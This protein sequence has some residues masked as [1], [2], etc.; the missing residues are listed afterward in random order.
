MTDGVIFD[1]DGTLIDSMEM[2]KN[3]DY[4]FLK[5]VGA[6]PDAD[7]TE[8]VNKMTLKEGIA[9]TK[10]RYHLPMSEDEILETIRQMAN[11]FYRGR[12]GLKPYV[13]EFLEELSKR[14][15]PMV[16]ATSSQ[17][18]FIL[19]ALKRNHAEHYF[20]DILSCA[21]L[22][23]NKTFPDV[24]LK[25][26]DA[27]GVRPENSWVIE[28][29]YHALMTAKNA[30]FRVAAVYDPSNDALLE[31]TIREADLYMEDLRDFDRFI[32]TTELFV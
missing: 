21:E 4:D 3:L 13:R 9:Y 31:E 23:I 1:A 24:F 19:N 32:K 28:D 7:Y 2:W 30:G 10:N 22:G 11:S 16:I 29:S 26:A 27:I 18:D 20:Q 12:A 5:S 8:T 14:K 17:T 6:V 25:A 15:I